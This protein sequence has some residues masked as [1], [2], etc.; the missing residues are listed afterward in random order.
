MFLC[1]LAYYVEWHLRQAWAELLYIDEE[2]SVRETPVSTAKPSPS[3]KQKKAKAHGINGLPLQSFHGLMQSLATMCRIRTRLGQGGPVYTR[4]T[5]P[6]PLQARA[7]E[8]IG[9]T[10]S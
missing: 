1:M 3:G 7:F 5:Q 2:G 6:T 10:A 8:L 4:T 9:V